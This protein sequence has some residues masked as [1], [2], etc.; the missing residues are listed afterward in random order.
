MLGGDSLHCFGCDLAGGQLVNETG[1]VGIESSIDGGKLFLGC[2]LRGFGRT[3]GRDLQICL[4]LRGRHLKR[5][6]T[7]GF[8]GRQ[9][10]GGCNLF[11]REEL[12]SQPDLIH[13]AIKSSSSV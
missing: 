2:G 10:D 8:C 1:L 11:N 4:S 5:S 7:H 13:Q 12:P 9:A 3:R 6:R